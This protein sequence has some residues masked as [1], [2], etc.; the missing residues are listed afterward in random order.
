MKNIVVNATALDTSG[1]LT[2]LKQFVDNIPNDINKNYIIFV[3]PKINFNTKKTNVNLIS[4]FK[5]KGLI[6]RFL[7]DCFG[8]CK[9]LKKHHLMPDV[10]ISLQNTNFRTGYKI[11][12]YI[13]YHQPLPFYPQHWSVWRRAE[14]ILWFYKYI[15]PFFVKLFMNSRTEVFV[16]LNY[17][18]VGFIKKYGV[19]SSKVHVIF[20]EVNLPKNVFDCNTIIFDDTVNLFYP[21]TPFFYKNHRLL[22]DAIKDINN[23]KIA[24][25]LTCD[26]EDLG[27]NIEGN[28]H[29]I[30]KVPY[31]VVFT[32]YK[33]CDA[34]VFP[35]Y[36]ETLGLPLVEAASVGCPIIASDLPFAR[37]VLNG[38]SG[39]TFLPYNDKEMWIKTI[40]QVKKGIR[41][42]PYIW[43]DKDS[44]AKLFEI[45]NNN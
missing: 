40:C 5:V 24:L 41:Y 1:A 38:Y 7:W 9:W 4:I 2:I 39:V 20:P 26:K 45:I 31:N 15:Y 13:Y 11:P 30:G 18:K 22:I 17:I 29:F 35:S 3:S 42:T 21:A 27:C 19:A 16:Q 14:R 25:Y 44:W 37:E 34:M 28:V 33:H 23:K 6:R 8:V 32:L 12:N 10:S 36:I 43:K